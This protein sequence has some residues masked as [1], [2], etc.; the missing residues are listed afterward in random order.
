MT[1]ATRSELRC[2]GAPLPVVPERVL[3]ARRLRAREPA[4]VARAQ[5]EMRKQSQLQKELELSARL[6]L[7]V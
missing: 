6:A 4:P 1:L 5:A 2:L 3:A 7:R